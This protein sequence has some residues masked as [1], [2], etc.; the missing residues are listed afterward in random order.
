MRQ[1]VCAIHKRGHINLYY[2]F[3]AAASAVGRQ[4]RGGDVDTEG[5]HARLGR[6]VSGAEMGARDRRWA[7]P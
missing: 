7:G 6:C 1:I 2:R 3:L 4:L 5:G